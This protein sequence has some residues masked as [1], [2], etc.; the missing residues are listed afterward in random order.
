MLVRE[1]FLA[2][3]RALFDPTTPSERT[4]FDR[5]RLDAMLEMLERHGNLTE[6]ELRAGLSKRALHITPHA[7]TTL[8]LSIERDGLIMKTSTVCHVGFRADSQEY[9]ISERGKGYHPKIHMLA[10][11]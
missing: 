7:L 1:R 8:L 5:Q 4:H 6:A 11:A 3:V 10:V 9:A 2:I